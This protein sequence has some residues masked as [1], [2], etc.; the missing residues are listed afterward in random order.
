[1]ITQAWL[2]VQ[3]GTSAGF[4]TG[5]SGRDGAEKGAVNNEEECSVT[6]HDE[7]VSTENGCSVVQGVY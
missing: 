1:M 6:A 3:V 2:Q 7:I 5:E 4:Y